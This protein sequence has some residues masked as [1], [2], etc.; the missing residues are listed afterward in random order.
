MF[1]NAQ[2]LAKFGFLYLN[3]GKW[4]NLQVLSKGWVSES[5]SKH[6][7][8][9]SGLGGNSGYGYQWWMN[10]FGGYSGRGYRGQ[11]LFVLPEQNMVVVFFSGLKDSDFFVPETLVADYLLPAIKSDRQL[12]EDKEASNLLLTKI[13]GLQSPPES[14][15][16]GALPESLK[17]ISGKIHNLPEDE[18]ISVDFTE[19]AEE[20]ILHWFVDGGQYDVPVGLD[21]R[22]R[23]STCDN[24]I[25]KG[26]ASQVGFR[27]TWTENGIF[28]VEI[29]PAESDT[30]YLLTLDF[31]KDKLVKTFEA[32]K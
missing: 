21:G 2:D 31:Q 30:R 24:F 29:C 9:P 26:L 23:M 7:E 25:I 14:Q 22:Y 28:S 6:I 3:E 1:M 27:G 32:V 12:P 20:A 8:T 5:T 4:D 17:G 15:G 18:V 16:V 10:P 19:G 11:Y 13:Y